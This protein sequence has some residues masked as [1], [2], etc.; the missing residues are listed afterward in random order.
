MRKIGKGLEVEGNSR[1][2]AISEKK[3]L[4]ARLHSGTGHTSFEISLCPQPC[5]NPPSPVPSCQNNWEMLSRGGRG[6][7]SRCAARG[8]LH[9]WRVAGAYRCSVPVGT[10]WQPKQSAGMRKCPRGNAPCAPACPSPAPLGFQ[11]EGRKSLLHLTPKWVPP[12]IPEDQTMNR[13]FLWPQTKPFIFSVCFFLQRS[14]L[15]ADFLCFQSQFETTSCK[16]TRLPFGTCRA[17]GD[18]RKPQKHRESSVLTA[19]LF[20]GGKNSL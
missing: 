7:F 17:M 6:R 5:V 8:V 10:G 3:H 14:R 12:P 4:K 11:R 13:E 9:S 20:P 19:P 18:F 1:V 2:R 16:A 15:C